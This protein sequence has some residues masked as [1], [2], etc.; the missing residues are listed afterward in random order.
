[1]ALFLQGFFGMLSLST[2]AA[3]L[4]YASKTSGVDRM[5]LSSI[6]DFADKIQNAVPTAPTTP[7]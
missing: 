6:I 4:D 7:P 1:M 5:L 3:A 2:S